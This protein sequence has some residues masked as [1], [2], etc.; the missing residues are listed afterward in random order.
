MERIAD[1]AGVE[2]G[3]ISLPD[4]RAV[5]ENVIEFLRDHER[6]TVTFS[7]GRYKTKIQKLAKERPG[8]CQIVFENQDG[9]LCAHIPTSWVKIIPTRL[10]SEEQRQEIGER[11]GRR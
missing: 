6:A 3:Q 8:E 11:L 9:S 2:V 5:N 1:L 7:H 10:L 4:T